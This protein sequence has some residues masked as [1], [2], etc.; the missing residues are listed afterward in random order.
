MRDSVREALGRRVRQKWIEWAQMQPYPKG[1]WLVPWESLAEPD[2]EV[3]RLIGEELWKL[4][5]RFAAAYLMTTHEGNRLAAAD[6]QAALLNGGELE[7]SAAQLALIVEE[8]LNARE[9]GT[10]TTR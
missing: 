7:G 6:L 10:G 8:Q 4:G 1:S 3:H 5:A 2:K 9:R